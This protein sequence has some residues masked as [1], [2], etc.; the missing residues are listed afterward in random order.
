MSKFN[1]TVKSKPDCKNLAGGEAYTESTKLEIASLILTSMCKNSFYSTE[2]NDISRLKHLFNQLSAEDK[3]FFAKAAIYARKEFGLRSISHYAAQ[4]ILESM[5]EKTYPWT[6]SFFN[7][8]VLRVDDMTEIASAYWS[9]SNKMLPNALRKGFRSAFDKFDNYQ[10]AKYK[11][12]NKEVSLIDLVNL[13]HPIPIKGKNDIALKELVSGELKQKETWNAQLSKAGSD[14]A[15]VDSSSKEEYL[16]EAKAEVWSKFVEKGD[17]VEMFALLR[18]LSNIKAQASEE[19]WKKALELLTDSRKIKNSKI[20]PFRFMTA[21][22]EL[23]DHADAK[24]AIAKAMELSLSNVPTLSGKT[25]IAVDDSGSMSPYGYGRF[26]VSSDTPFTK[27]SVF[28]ASLFK[29]L[30]CDVL[31]FNTSARYFREGNSL[32][33]TISIIERLH[34]SARGGG[35]SFESIFNSAARS[36][37]KYDR[38]IILSDMQSWDGNTKRGLSLYR[39]YFQCDPKLYMIDITGHGTLQFP[40]RN[41]YCVAGFSEKIF[42]LIAK[43][44]TDREAMIHAI[45]S[46]EL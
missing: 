23:K 24:I 29:K 38:I 26:K 27:A 4:I 1:S 12:E 45:E 43:L 7:Q 11:A 32:D 41:C 13:I 30:S 3:S 28:A 44:E 19:T 33:S 9:K 36:K 22:E 20:L 2:Q 14:A 25:L 39:S 16:K 15:K 10:L 46:I 31:L 8:V 17:K 40:E 35:T 5:K 34:E 18:N 37:I 42:D 6:K 21:Y